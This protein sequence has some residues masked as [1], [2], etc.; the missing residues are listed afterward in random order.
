MR[1]T[2]SLDHEKLSVMFAR[3]GCGG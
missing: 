3:V 1:E 2:V